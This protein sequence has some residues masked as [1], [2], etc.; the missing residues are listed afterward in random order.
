MVKQMNKPNGPS[1]R[2]RERE[3]ERETTP[4]VNRVVLVPQLYA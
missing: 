3:R 2:E 4:S 1:E